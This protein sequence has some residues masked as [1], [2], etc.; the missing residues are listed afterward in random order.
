MKHERKLKGQEIVWVC[1]F[2]DR[3]FKTEKES[4]KHQLKCIKN[5]KNKGFALN[6]SPKKAWIYFWL[7][8]ILTFGLSTLVLVKLSNQNIDILLNQNLLKLFLGNICLGIIAFLIMAFSSFVPRKNQVN[9]VT[10]Y[11]LY[12]CFLY[13]ATNSSIFAVE[14]FKAKADPNYIKKFLP[15][16]PTPTPIP[17]DYQNSLI[18]KINVY[19]SNQKLSNLSQDDELCKIG[20]RYINQNDLSVDSLKNKDDSDICPKC[21]DNVLVWTGINTPDM[22]VDS[23]EKDE[24]TKKTLIGKYKYIC[25]V[26]NTKTVMFV[27]A[28]KNTSTTNNAVK[29]NSSNI[30]CIGPDGKHFNTS[31]SECKKLNESWGKT[32]NYMAYCNIG[33]SCPAEKRW[34]SYQDCE[35]GTCCQI[36]SSWIFYTSVDKCKQDQNNYGKASGSYSSGGS[37]NVSNNSNSSPKVTFEATETSI[38]GTYYCYENMVN[39]MVSQQSYVKTLREL[40]ESCINSSYNKSVY[41]NCMNTNNCDVHDT[42]ENSCFQ[43]C[44]NSGYSQC[45]EYNKNYYSEKSKLDQMRWTNCP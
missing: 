17:S 35:N 43:N 6:S 14:G 27:F 11:I 33:G 8:T 12:I 16:S 20:E 34:M 4:N 22:V 9:K 26:Y 38:K 41:T 10:K 30:E 24:D 44:Y 42:S 5:P 2:C 7:T 18:D 15:V 19:R 3:E 21:S 25:V 1:D 31:I 13:L 29:N 37:S 40:Y 23:L 32:L 28:N 45:N 39:S 36:G